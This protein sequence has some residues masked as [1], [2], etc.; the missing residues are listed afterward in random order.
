MLLRLEGHGSLHQ[1]LYRALRDL[2]RS[3]KWQHG[4]RLP[5]SRALALEL[6][7]SRNVVL[8]A[9]E[10]LNAEGYVRCRMGSG[11]FVSAALPD[12]MLAAGRS[13]GSSAAPRGSQQPIF[14]N[15]GRRVL[16]KG[17][18]PTARSTQRERPLPYDFQYGL[19]STEEF[20]HALWRRLTARRL[21][22]LSG[23]YDFQEGSVPLR[24]AIAD[25]LRR[26][27]AVDCRP[28]Q[29]LVVTGSQQALDIA[30]RLLLNP[31][32][33]VVIEDP[34]YQ[35]AREMFQSAGAKMIP[36]PVDQQGLR[37]D[38]LSR[39]SRV[40]RLAYVTPSHQFPTG[41]ILSLD[42]RLSLLAWASR[43]RAYIL[44]DD[45]DAEFRY[46]GR[47]LESMQ[48][49][50]RAGR[51]IYI[52]TF[53]RIFFP[54]MRVG[55][56][57][58]P[59]PLVRAFSEAKWLTDRHTPTLEQEVLTDFI[60]EGHLERYLRRSRSRN[61]ARRAALLS[62]LRKYFGG[63]IEVSGTD[64]GIHVL[65]RLKRI[66]AKQV[67][68]LIE[69]AAREGVGIYPAAPYYL[70]KPRRAEI[71]LGY[72]ALSERELHEGIR[73]LSLHC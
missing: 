2:I 7:I 34:H 24:A 46:T 63:S 9:Y 53:S 28:E 14:S 42:R 38:L 47:P 51:V 25:Y 26:F 57:V 13:L 65:V 60:Q 40:A 31:G 55:Y 37:V 39:S 73:I 72:S 49:L 35:G 19:S 23:D 15:Y 27:R 11:T 66:T 6:G 54:S 29:V 45:F 32:N 4:K 22:G 56:M 30:S 17:P 12:S 18:S 58:L 20:P 44:E 21:R 64:S 43:N 61:A 50:D 5:A 59:Q 48:G 36:V 1:Q 62:A 3:G 69:R 71:L 41:A 10:E 16:G 52:G 67:P 70:R 68:A 33:S 8:M